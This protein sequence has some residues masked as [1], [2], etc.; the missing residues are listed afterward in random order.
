VEVLRSSSETTSYALGL[1]N[2]VGASNKDLR[3][4]PILPPPYYTD[5]K[6][7]EME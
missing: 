1:S 7:R 2:S 6:S 5:K 4:H 3:D